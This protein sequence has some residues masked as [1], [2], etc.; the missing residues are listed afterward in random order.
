MDILRNN[1]Q[2]HISSLP[3]EATSGPIYDRFSLSKTSTSDECIQ[4]LRRWGLMIIP[5]FVD[6]G[7]LT[8]LEQEF[9]QIMSSRSSCVKALETT[10]SDEL[11]CLTR[12][13]IKSGELTATSKLFS[14]RFMK[15]ILDAYLGRRNVLNDRIYVEKRLIGGTD[16]TK[17]HY[18]HKRQFKFFL[19]LTDTTEENGALRV[20]PGSHKFTQEQE[21][22]NRK[23]RILP[24]LGEPYQFA[25]RWATDEILSVEG[26][27][28]TMILFDSDVLH[29]RGHVHHGERKVM[30]GHSRIRPHLT[31]ASFRPKYLF[32]SMQQVLK[33]RVA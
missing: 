26:K 32:R 11:R 4:V 3:L 33:R 31:T 22:G 27:K 1:W 7:Y 24:S 10:G 21:L 29:S 13:K 17:L 6:L 16:N 20:V 18:D 19:Y 5:D 23:K 12:R 15:T 14:D 25:A 9:D 28:G 8:S 2:E 30:R